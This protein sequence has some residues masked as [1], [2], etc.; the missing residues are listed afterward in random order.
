MRGHVLRAASRHAFR[1]E[2]DRCA[3]PRQRAHGAVQRPRGARAAAGAFVLRI[4]DTDAERSDDALLAARCSRTCAGS[5]SHWDEG[6]DVGGAHGP[7]RAERAR[8]PSMRRRSRRWRRP[9]RAYPCFCTPDE[10]EAV[11]QG[12]AR[13]RP[14][15]AVCR[16]L[17]VR[18]RPRKCARRTAA[19]ERPALRFRVPAGTQRRVRRPGA[20]PAAL[21]DR[22]HRRFRDPPRRRQRRR[23]SSAT[24]STTR[25]WGST[26]VLRGDDHLAN[27]PRQILLLRGARPAAAAATAHLPLLLGADGAPLSKRDG[28]AEPAATCARRATCR[29]RCATTWCGSGTP[30]GATAGSRPDALAQHFDLGAHAASRAARFDEAQLRHWQREA[31]RPRPARRRCSAWL[32]GTLERARRRRASQRVR[33]GG[34]RQRA[35][36]GGRRRHWWRWS[37]DA[38][39][40]CRR[41]GGRADR[42]GGCR[43]SSSSALARWRR[44]GADFK[45]W[46]RA[47]GAGH[48]RAKAQR[49]YMPLRAALTGTHAR[50][51]TRAA[52]RPDGR[53]SA[54]AARHRRAPRASGR[55]RTDGLRIE[56]TYDAC[57]RSTT[58]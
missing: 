11:A 36:P 18:C 13:R 55:D 9:G 2:P 44:N 53:R 57:C 52:R 16:H 30:V 12:A 42:G 41:R 39:L 17:R 50:A 28:A 3:A 48:R 4:E 21:R 29:A 32:A 46:T 5:A 23:S 19:G 26:L 7:Y 45:A 25:R 10:L 35:V 15:A 38:E 49:C 6:P 37:C 31:V 14:P 58:R 40:A 33:R 47:V 54:S 20:R 22:R 24:R 27:T 1:A 56:A 34:A 43:R 51:G 8:R